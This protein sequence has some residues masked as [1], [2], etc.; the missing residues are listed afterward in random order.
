MWQLSFPYDEG[1]ARILAK[2][3]AALKVEVLRRCGEWHKP[4]PALLRNTPLDCMS[5]YPVYDRDLLDPDILR[6][7]QMTTQLASAQPASQRRVTVIGD[8]AH[9][10]SPFK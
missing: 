4:I 8:A 7:P 1:A 5:G 3:P 10:M 6:I 2:D 9:P